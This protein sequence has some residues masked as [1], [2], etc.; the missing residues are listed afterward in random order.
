VGCSPDLAPET[1]AFVTVHGLLYQNNPEQKA[2]LI[3]LFERSHFFIVPTTAE[4]FGIVFAEA[5]A[6]ALPPISRAVHAVPSVIVDGKTG[7]LMDPSAP[8]SDYVE[9]IL[10]LW[11]NQSAYREMALAGRDRF[12]QL[13]NWDHTAE[14]IVR[15]IDESLMQQ[16]SVRASPRSNG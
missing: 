15:H 14:S 8:A 6:F 12:E 7:I 5:Q 11:R 4:C 13:L 10:T 3:G 16:A 9:R 1:S 2:A